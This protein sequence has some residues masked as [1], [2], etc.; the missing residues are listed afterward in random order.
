MVHSYLL[1][2]LVDWICLDPRWYF[3]LSSHSEDMVPR[4]PWIF[5]HVMVPAWM[6]VVGKDSLDGNMVD[7]VWL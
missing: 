7:V 3:G 6:L 2:C 5:R 1:F 4:M